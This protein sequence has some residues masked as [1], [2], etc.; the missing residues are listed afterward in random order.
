MRVGRGW[1]QVVVALVVAAAAA[2]PATAD[3]RAEPVP[4]LA[5]VA[6]AAPG[7][8]PSLAVAA[9]AGSRA[10]AGPGTA[11]PSPN[12]ECISEIEFLTISTGGPPVVAQ[13]QIPFCVK[14]TVVT[15]FHGSRADGC[16]A[17]GLCGYRGSVT[18]RPRGGE[19]V[20]TEYAT[21]PRRTWKTFEVFDDVRPRVTVGRAVGG[22]VVATCRDRGVGPNTVLGEAP[23]RDGQ[24][25]IRLPSG[26][27]NQWND[28]CAGP[29]RATLPALPAARMPLEGML[30]GVAGSSIVRRQRFAGGGWA[31][32]V[33]AHLT[34]SAGPPE[35]HRG[36]GHRPTP[37]RQRER[38][39]SVRYRASFT[40]AALRVD[41][42]H[43]HAGCAVLDACGLVGSERLRA[44]RPG[45]G[46]LELEAYGP[47]D[48]PERDFLTALGVGRGGDPSGITMNALDLAGV[49]LRTTATTDQD[50]VRCRSTGG[51]SV[52]L[53]A[54]SSHRA[55]VFHAVSLGDT[56]PLRTSCAGP[57]LAGRQL[58]AARPSAGAFA[59]RHVTL[60]FPRATRALHDGGFEMRVHPRLQLALSRMGISNR[61]LSYASAGVAGCCRG[62]R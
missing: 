50:G 58:T 49:P 12:S 2:S 39:V 8:V 55:L 4:S 36:S 44:A 56:D 53:Y 17:H 3:G 45:A 1:V 48:R 21:H 41:W 43:V 10:D 34:F 13:R 60:S 59:S 27:T 7:P 31:G 5:R 22:H 47:A 25:T 24:V 35:H 9:A 16:A 18:W 46:I 26:G 37:P 54:T 32:T 14:G 40:T 23:V 42:S 15:T 62:A 38:L 30:H 11:A 51:G 61:I 29:I 52:G 57:V 28:R 33:A 6:A 20:A 19:L